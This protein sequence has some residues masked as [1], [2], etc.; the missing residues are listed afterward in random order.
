MRPSSLVGVH[1]VGGSLEQS[2][3]RGFGFV[4]V[5]GNAEVEVGERIAQFRAEPGSALSAVLVLLDG[6]GRQTPVWPEL[7]ASSS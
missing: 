6:V 3:S 2:A 1:V 5:A 7:T 4:Q